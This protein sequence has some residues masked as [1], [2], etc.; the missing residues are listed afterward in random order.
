MNF[1]T[2]NFL[3]ELSKG[4]K[5]LRLVFGSALILAA[6]F[7]Q[8]PFAEVALLPLLA[9][10]PI[11]TGL[12]GVDPFYFLWQK[13]FGM[14]TQLCAFSRGVL[15]VISAAMIGAV[16]SGEGELGWQGIL[17]IMAVYPALAAI[18]GN[19]PLNGFVYHR[20]DNVVTLRTRTQQPA[21]V[22]KA[23]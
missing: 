3:G 10:Y 20:Q 21:S 13:V 8:G 19:D 18:I 5:A 17:A 23:A 12:I 11:M 9:V 4:Q 14:R 15:L 7:Y 2:S 22:R 16:M 6:M 1:T